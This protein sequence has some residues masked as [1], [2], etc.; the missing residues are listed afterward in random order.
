M[1]ILI[2]PPWTVLSALIGVV[3]GSLFH[4][5]FGKGLRQL[6]SGLGFAVAGAVL[7]GLLGIWIPPAILA[8]GDTNLIATTL[9]AWAALAVGR[10]FRFC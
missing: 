8:I 1:P 4:I 10:V 2:I 9:A 3:H 7:G 6:A 5:F